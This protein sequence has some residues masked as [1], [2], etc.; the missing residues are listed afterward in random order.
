MQNYNS[1]LYK[2]DVENPKLSNFFDII[3]LFPSL[4][5]SL[6]KKKKLYSY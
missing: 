2:T 6:T 5:F 1:Q 3:N 4:A